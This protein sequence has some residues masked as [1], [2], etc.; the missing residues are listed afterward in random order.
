MDSNPVASIICLLTRSKT[1]TGPERAAVAGFR[2]AS[3]AP[4]DVP[5]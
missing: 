3:S 2:P 4:D 1:T 5:L